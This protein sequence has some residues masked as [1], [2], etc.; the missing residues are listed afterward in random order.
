MSTLLPLVRQP[1]RAWCWIHLLLLRETEG[2]LSGVDFIVST[3]IT[4]RLEN[5]PTSHSD[6]MMS[7]CLPL[8]NKWCVTLFVCVCSNSSSWICRKRQVLLRALQQ[9]PK[10]PCRWQGHNSWRFQYKIEP[11]CRFL[12]KITWQTWHW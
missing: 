4:S 7:M 11:R 12:E 6:H 2:R 9:F 10:H 5:L 8:K 3:S 1:P